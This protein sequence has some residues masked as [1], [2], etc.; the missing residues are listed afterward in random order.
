MDHALHYGTLKPFEGRWWGLNAET[1]QSDQD[2]LSKQ[3]T[4]CLSYTSLYSYLVWIK[5]QFW[6]RA[7][8]F[9]HTALHL[10]RYQ[11]LMCRSWGF[12]TFFMLNLTQHEIS[13]LITVKMLKNN[14]FLTLLLTVPRQYFFCVSFMFFL[15][16]VCYAFVRVCLY[17]PC[18]HLLGKGWPLVSRLWC[19]PVSLSL[20]HWYPGSGVVLRSIDSWSLHP[21]LL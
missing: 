9:Y 4:L 1:R 15:S 16:Y 5:S 3:T 7:F 13:I 19:L 18:S 14:T 11:P 10:D 17:M 8:V 2:N 6:S 21:Y 20:S 12:K